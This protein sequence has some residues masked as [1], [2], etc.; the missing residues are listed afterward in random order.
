MSEEVSD[1]P[2]DELTRY[3]ISIR[4]KAVQSITEKN[5]LK[6]RRAEILE[7]LKSHD[8]GDRLYPE[9]EEEL[10]LLEPLVTTADEVVEKLKEEMGG[11][12]SEIQ[13]RQKNAWLRNVPAARHEE[14]LALQ[15]EMAKE[16]A[17][18]RGSLRTKYPMFSV[19]T[20]RRCLLIYERSKLSADETEQIRKLDEEAQQVDQRL[21]EYFDALEA[22]RLQMIEIENGY[23]AKVDAMRVQ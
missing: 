17:S 19:D 2:G 13:A 3:I 5:R 22:R 10:R 1:E 18:L 4:E 21:I 12:A 14:A 7:W 20:H 6:L 16:L 8:E 15:A 9:S 11:A 23:K